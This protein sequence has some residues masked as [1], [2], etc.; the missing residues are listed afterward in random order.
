MSIKNK[1]N[2]LGLK[3]VDDDIYYKYL[4]EMELKGVEVGRWKYYKYYGKNNKQIMFYSLE[5]LSK[6]TI[7]ELVQKDNE[8]KKLFEPSIIERLYR[9]LDALYMFFYL[10]KKKLARMI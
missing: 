10:L 4:R 8:N 5:Y 3:K 7:D 9:K 1:V 6:H 2:L